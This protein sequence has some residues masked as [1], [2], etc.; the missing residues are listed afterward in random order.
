MAIRYTTLVQ[1]CGLPR[2]A[3]TM[4]L[5]SFQ[6]ACR[7]N[8]VLTVHHAEDGDWFTPHWAETACHI[9]NVVARLVFPK[10][11]PV[12]DETV[13]LGIRQHATALIWRAAL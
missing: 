7:E 10:P 5:P 9:F 2:V 11:L 6:K 1:R 4:R 13:V 12:P 3:S 8:R